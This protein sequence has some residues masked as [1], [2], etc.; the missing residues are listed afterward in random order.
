MLITL[1]N[2]R[3]EKFLLD[4]NYIVEVT[5]LSTEGQSSD[6]PKSSVNTTIPNQKQD[7]FNAYRV[8]EDV[9]E[10]GRLY[11]QAMGVIASMGTHTPKPL[12]VTVEEP[13]KTTKKASKKPASRPKSVQQA[14]KETVAKEV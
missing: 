14:V 7:G 13:K 2:Q 11:Y 6:S 4:A 12:P 3:K 8:Y 9:Q 10:V 1:T 5:P